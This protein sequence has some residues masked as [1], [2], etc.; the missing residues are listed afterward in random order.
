MLNTAYYS[1][2]FS[3]PHTL[4]NGT[5]TREISVRETSIRNIFESLKNNTDKLNTRLHQSTKYACQ[6]QKEQSDFLSNRKEAFQ[7][8]SA[9]IK[10]I[11]KGQLKSAI[12]LL[13]EALTL[14]SFGGGETAYCQRYLG[15]ACSKSKNYNDAVAFYRQALNSGRLSSRNAAFCQRSMGLALSNLNRYEESIEYFEAALKSKELLP[16]QTPHCERDLGIAL[17]NTEQYDDAQKYLSSALNNLFLSQKSRET[18]EN[19]IAHMEQEQ[20]QQ[21]DSLLKNFRDLMPQVIVNAKT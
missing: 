4:V 12:S 17:F 15:L 14:Y 11:R 3:A 6:T 20:K 19:F 16:A 10:K 2:F 18:C 8:Q 7:L 9:G 13:K 5:S 21:L 1:Q